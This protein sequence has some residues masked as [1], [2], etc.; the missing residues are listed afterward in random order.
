MNGN[1]VD[2]LQH[3]DDNGDVWTNWQGAALLP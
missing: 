2:R 3:R 1:P